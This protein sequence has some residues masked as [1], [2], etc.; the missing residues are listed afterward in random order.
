[1]L[2]LAGACS[3]VFSHTVFG[4]DAEAPANAGQGITNSPHDFSQVT[5]WIP[6][7]EICVICHAPHNGVEADEGLLWNHAITLNDGSYTLYSSDTLDGVIG[8]PVG[9]SKLCLSCHD[10]SV[11]VDQYADRVGTFFISENSNV[12]IGF[13]GDL[14]AQHPVSITYAWADCV[15]DPNATGDCEL[16][17]P[18]TV[19]DSILPGTT[20]IPLAVAD[21]L[22]GEQVQC[23]SCHDVHN[24]IE[25]TGHVKLLRV[26]RTGSAICLSC[27]AK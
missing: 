13:G 24:G 12:S 11:A 25:V 16:R 22:E 26:D 19:I 18:T 23:A 7:G 17:D 27:H 21:L 9:S 6:T 2:V 4:V 20:A 3:L 8:Q 1:M 10:G 15:N 5:S 14:T